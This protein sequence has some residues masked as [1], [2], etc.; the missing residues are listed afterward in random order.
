MCFHHYHLH[1]ICPI[2]STTRPII[3]KIPIIKT[4]IKQPHRNNYPHHNTRSTTPSTQS[5][6]CFHHNHHNVFT[7]ITT[8]FSPQSPQCFHHNHHNVFTT[9]TTMFSP[10]S[11]Q[12]FHH[13]HHNVFTTITTM[14]SPQSPQC[15]HHNHHNVF[16]TITTTNYFSQALRRERQ[17]ACGDLRHASSCTPPTT[18]TPPSKLLQKPVFQEVQNHCVYKRKHTLTIKH[19]HTQN[20]TRT[21]K[22]TRIHK[23]HLQTNKHVDKNMCT[24]RKTYVALGRSKGWR[25]GV[26][27][28][29]L[30]STCTC[31]LHLPGSLRRNLKNDL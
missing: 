21:L 2:T 16:T 8:M 15:F 3:T 31:L 22:H 6:Q 4:T 1:S 20:H 30:H 7:T 24:Q 11:P 19:T 18:G 14:F 5:P 10:Q 29:T 26:C 28:P 27:W 25:L 13:N 17:Q 23:K 12:C 9:I